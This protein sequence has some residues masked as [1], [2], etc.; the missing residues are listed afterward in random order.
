VRMGYLPRLSSPRPNI[1]GDFR[2]IELLPGHR[3]RFRRPLCID[4]GNIL[5]HRFQGCELNAVRHAP[6]V[7]DLRFPYTP[8]LAPNSEKHPDG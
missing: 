1:K 4:L 3:V 2:D 8:I 6:I 7:R 5:N